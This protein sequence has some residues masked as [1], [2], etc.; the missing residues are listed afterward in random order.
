MKQQQIC[1][2]FDFSHNQVSRKQY[3]DEKI[4]SSEN[5]SPIFCVDFELP[6]RKTNPNQ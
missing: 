1:V 4:H 6:N 3:F 2:D 5:K